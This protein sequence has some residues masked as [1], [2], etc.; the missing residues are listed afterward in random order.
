[1][2]QQLTIH[3]DLSLLGSSPGLDLAL[4]FDP[5]PLKA[6]RRAS[7]QL[8]TSLPGVQVVLWQLQAGALNQL[9]LRCWRWNP[10]GIGGL[11]V[12]ALFGL[13]LALQAQRRSIVPPLP[14]L[15]S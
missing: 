5:L 2:A 12:A 9:E 14:A 3:L 10:L 15:P 8:A 13:A 4:K 7:P 1:V 6:V 11:V